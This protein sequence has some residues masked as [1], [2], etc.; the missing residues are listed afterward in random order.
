MTAKN[1]STS[2]RTFVKGTAASAAIAPFFIGRSAMAS[3]TIKWKGAT[4]APKGT[5]WE[6]MATKMK[7]QLEADS[8]GA[9][10]VNILFGGGAGDE[11][12]TLKACKD[13]RLDV[14]AGSMGSASTAVPELGAFELPY[15]FS[16]SKS[17]QKAMAA[18]RTLVH[19]LLWE[20]GFKLVMFAENGYRSLGTTFP[21]ETPADLKGRK[22]RI[23]ESK[24]HADLFAAW[25]ASGVPM[26]ITEVLP[27]LQTG[28]I[29][30]ADNSALFT[31]ATGLTMALT[32]WTV[33][34]HI[35][36]PAVILISRK[37]AWDKLPAE[38][39]ASLSLDSEAMMKIEDRGFRSVRSLEEQ[40]MQNFS[41][42][43]LKIHKP[44]LGPWKKAA[45]GVHEKFR[46]RTTK[47]GIALLE[48]ITKA[49]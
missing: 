46:K 24:I 34:E 23:Q 42:M 40:L 43:G 1:P 11:G 30:G 36:Q 16:S 37:G 17:A 12:T 4:V 21:V 33:T 32:D 44:D 15:L 35:Y 18:T 22:I 19:D 5:A 47:Q 48:A 31:Q 45:D 14:W 2:R 41:D 20:G 49:T 6:Q 7:K 25:G 39:Q 9:L 10:K 8:G 29:E 3:E 27:S 26:G 38:L 28:V 13:G